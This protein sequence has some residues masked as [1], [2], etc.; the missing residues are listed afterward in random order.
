MSEYRQSFEEAIKLLGFKKVLTE[1]LNVAKIID[2][3]TVGQVIIHLNNG[4]VTKI[5]WNN[6]EIKQ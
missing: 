6:L 2:Q 4:G 1:L 3:D 5:C